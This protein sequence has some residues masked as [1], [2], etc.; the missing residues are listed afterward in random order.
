L[1]GESDSYSSIVKG[2]VEILP[3]ALP[4]KILP[5]LDNAEA[6]DQ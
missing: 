5:D 2:K 3:G 4:G 1:Y 6:A